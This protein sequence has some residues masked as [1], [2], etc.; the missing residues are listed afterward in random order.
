MTVINWTKI[1]ET[2]ASDPG[3]WMPVIAAI[4]ALWVLAGVAWASL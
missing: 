4:I 3:F 1:R 2:I